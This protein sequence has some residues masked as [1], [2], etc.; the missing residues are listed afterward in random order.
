MRF[1]RD[2]PITQKEDRPLQSVYS[3]GFWRVFG[4]PNQAE[5]GIV[6]LKKTTQ[7]WTLGYGQNKVN[8]LTREYFLKGTPDKVLQTFFSPQIDCWSNRSPTISPQ[9][10]LA[11]K[12]HQAYAPSCSLW[13]SPSY[14]KSNMLSKQKS[15]RSCRKHG[16]GYQ[17]GRTQ[18]RINWKIGIGIYTLLFATPWSVA[19]QVSLSMEF[20]RQEYWSELPFP[21][22]RNLPDPGI[23]PVSSESPALAGGSITTTP[24]GNCIA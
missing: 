17:G 1:G 11:L 5:T 7:S 13:N 9:V 8:K 4:F 10:W 18:G 12:M 23:N 24:P 15:S 22:P 6:K 20:S 19:C 3:V 21:P 14:F 16:Y 2:K